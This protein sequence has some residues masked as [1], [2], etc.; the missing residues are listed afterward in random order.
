MSCEIRE[1][2]FFES[3]QCQLTNRKWLRQCALLPKQ[4]WTLTINK[5]ITVN[6]SFNIVNLEL[7]N[8]LI[9]S[10]ICKF[11]DWLLFSNIS[12]SLYIM[13]T[14]NS[15]QSLNIYKSRKIVQH[16]NFCFTVCCKWSRF[17]GL[18]RKNLTVTITCTY[19]SS[20]NGLM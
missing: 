3:A 18:I 5:Y 1:R 12:Q 6:I 13:Q 20:D 17:W 15:N 4:R 9:Y 11:K 8:I 16:Q 7:K 19:I 14:K 2:W 10:E